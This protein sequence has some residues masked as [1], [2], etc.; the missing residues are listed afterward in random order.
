MRELGGRRVEQSERMKHG[1]GLGFAG[2]RNKEESGGGFVSG[3]RRPENGETFTIFIDG[4]PTNISKRELY[5]AFGIYGFIADVFVSRKER[6]KN[7]TPYRFAFVRYKFF[8]GAV[9]AIEGMNGRKWG[10][11]KL[12]VMM[13][14]YRRKE[15]AKRSSRSMKKNKV[16]QKWVE[17]RKN[18]ENLKQKVDNCEEGKADGSR[19][20]EVEV[21]WSPEQEQR[22]KKSLLGV[23][24]KPID[25]RHVMNLLLDEWSGEGKI[26]VRDVGPYRCL[27]TFC[28]EEIKNAALNDQLLLSVFDKVRPHWELFGSLSRRV[29]IEVIGMPIKLWSVE[30]F[31]RIARQW[32]KVVRYDDRA[33]EGKSFRVA[34]ILIDSFQ[35]ELINEW[36]T[37]KVDNHRFDILVKEFGWEVYNIQSHPDRAEGD[38]I[39]SRSSKSQA[40]A[41][42]DNL[43]EVERSPAHTGNGDLFHQ[44]FNAAHIDGVDTNVWSNEPIDNRGAVSKRQKPARDENLLEAQL[45]NTR[46]ME[47]RR[48]GVDLVEKE[49][50]DIGLDE[51]QE[52]CCPNYCQPNVNAAMVCGPNVVLVH[53]PQG[54]ED[55]VSA[56][57]CPY[58][59]GFG[60]CGAGTHVHNEVRAENTSVR[61]RETQLE[62]GE[63]VLETHLD[64]ASSS[65]S[66]ASRET[67][68]HEDIK[69]SS[70]TLYR[71]NPEKFHLELVCDT[72]G[73][74]EVDG[75]GVV[76]IAEPGK[77][78]AKTGLGDASD[79]ISQVT[80]SEVRRAESDPMFPLLPQNQSADG[81]GGADGY[82]NYNVDGKEA[83][84]LEDKL[85]VDSSADEIVE[86]SGDD[87]PWEA[88]QLI[89]AS[90]SK[91]VW[92]RSG[93]FFD[94]SE[95]EEILD[96]LIDRKSEKRKLKKQWTVI[97]TSYIQGRSLST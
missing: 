40:A 24:A 20:K 31:D 32:G 17:V 33:E 77:G 88:E 25:L 72:F 92:D 53:G 74:E 69:S 87:E 62:G 63:A 39:S 50:N 42:V 65:R 4:L 70:E 51:L 71:I 75:G 41:V 37:V 54:L 49:P 96:K 26:E 59:P 67:P 94:S 16:V 86:E 44:K 46:D 64:N 66:A 3:V 8:A 47:G 13:S 35:W 73:E 78:V 30:N 15:D 27:I 93:I 5:K 12:L 14:K 2:R 80:S 18:G 56:F 68:P 22:L 95:E 81:D 76:V 45:R 48:I 61:V 29:W 85:I 10:N 23:C 19:R 6:Q 52:K 82:G 28:S 57:S 36:I 60:P 55:N 34:R 21:V 97:N 43:V 79:D 91:K 11:L 1:E 83:G 84:E 89:E 7:G 90:E 58:P 38:S 9:K